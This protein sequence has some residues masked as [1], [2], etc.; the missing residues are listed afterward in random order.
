MGTPYYLNK[1]QNTTAEKGP[2]LN[3]YGLGNRCVII[4]RVE[5]INIEQEILKLRLNREHV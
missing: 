1:K 4:N 5:R 3:V 2:T